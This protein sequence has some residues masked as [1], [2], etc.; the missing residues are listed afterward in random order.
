[1]EKQSDRPGKI[2]R[3][4]RASRRKKRKYYG[5][6]T[7]LPI[8]DA[9][10]EIVNIHTTE[11]VVSASRKKLKLDH[12]SEDTPPVSADNIDCNL[13]INTKLM[14]E[15]FK[16]LCKC[17][18]CGNN[19]D[20][21]HD[22]KRKRG[23]A[24]FLTSKCTSCDWT[25]EFSTSKCVE[26][27]TS[28][29]GRKAYEIN[30]RS[31][32]AFREIGKGLEGLRSVCKNMNIPPPMQPN[33]FSNITNTLHSSYT[34]VANKSM[35]IASKEIP[36]EEDE[37]KIKDVIASFDGTW[38]K[39]G[40]A[41]LNGVVAAV[42]HGKVVDA[43]VMSK[44]CLSC[45]YWN[46]PGRKNT[47]EFNDWKDEHHC[48][49]NHKGS[50]G[51]MESAGVL[52]IYKRSVVERSLRYTTYLG[53][54][55]S[56][57]FQ[58]IINA[59]PYPGKTCNRYECVGHVQKR[60]TAHINTLKQQYKGVVLADHKK[61]CGKGRLTQK[62][63]NTLQNYYGMVIRRNS[64]D[65]YAMKK[66]IAAIIH[67]CS[68]CSDS[69]ERHKFCPRDDKS[70]C[71]YQREKNS[72]GSSS[73]VPKIN[74]PKAVSDIVKIVFSHEDLGS[75]TLLKKCLHGQTQNVNESFNGLVWKRVPKDVFVCKRTLQLGV[76]SATIAYNDG[77]KGLLNVFNNC[78]IEPGYFTTLGCI[79]YDKRR[80]SVMDKKT[81]KVNKKRRRTL[82]DIRKGWVDQH[83]ETEGVT[84]GAG[85][86]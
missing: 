73:Y 80:V 70:W 61:L 4:N 81:L 27:G 3:K 83:L 36:V 48:P 19:I 66:D 34:T 76:A 7:T 52:Q 51:S 42:S 53:D 29:Q 31:C 9:L 11:E 24:H 65:L 58:D 41:S 10:N 69:D 57:S 49:I 77:A 79:Q 6:Q 13:I 55:D 54:G 15:F 28:K 1:M 18:D 72:T 21:I 25:D 33:V 20:I 14:I 82:R 2:G 32:I 62:V 59:D 8:P 44:V 84:Y 75:D 85:K 68:E 22:H 12:Q 5:N 16:K 17:P 50:A 60:V 86:F 35:Q 63:T 37:Y 56:K 43:E 30:I 40:Y 39:R 26:P 64:G 74:I 46:Q 71:R 47:P 38:Q 78:R 23:L 67:H 45:R